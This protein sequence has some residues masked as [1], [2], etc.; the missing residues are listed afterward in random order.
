MTDFTPTTKRL[1]VGS[2]GLFGFTITLGWVFGMIEAKDA[3]IPL[4]MIIGGF[5]SLL[6]G[7]E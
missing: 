4:S 3:M 1:I 6:K 7:V 2:I 5:L